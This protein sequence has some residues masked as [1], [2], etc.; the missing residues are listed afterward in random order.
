MLN[1]EA[2][3]TG[4]TV[5]GLGTLFIKAWLIVLLGQSLY[6]QCEFSPASIRH[7]IWMAALLGL[8]T[9]PLLTLLLPTWTL[10]FLSFE[11]SAEEMFKITEK[12]VTSASASVLIVN[13]LIVVYLSIA[14]LQGLRLAKSVLDI[15][16]ITMRAKPVDEQWMLLISQL[17]TNRRGQIKVSAEVK[18]PLTWGLLSPVIIVPERSVHWSEQERRMVLLHEFS[19]INRGDWFMQFLGQLVCILYWPVPGVRRAFDKLSLEAE[20]ACDDKVLGEGANAADYA[21]LLLRQARIKKL[22]ASVGLIQPS[23]FGCRVRHIVSATVDRT[24][25][26][27]MK[28]LLLTF[29]AVF[30]LPYASFQATASLRP[31]AV[32]VQP[33][34]LLGAPVESSS[35]STREIWAFDPI[36][37]PNR[38]ASVPSPPPLT[39][40]GFESTDIPKTTILAKFEPES[41]N[42]IPL[43]V[44]YIEITPAKKVMSSHPS[45]PGIA[46]RRGIEGRVVVQYDVDDT[47]TVLNPK[48]VYSQPEHVFN[49]SVLKAI[50]GYQFEPYRENGKALPVTGLREEFHFQLVAQP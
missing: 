44:E 10:S 6:E 48:V 20:Q 33:L 17:N 3:I 14:F 40:N 25:E 5:Y 38:P 2:L 12:G 19:H 41:L 37:R 16:L 18:S 28:R 29:C 24:G 22:Q 7:S 11:V 36:D 34:A 32:L 30:M 21:H 43:E 13:S 1:H 47:G 31:N 45:Y 26:K 15:S 42:P 35:A 27:S 39:I 23:E 8:F 49:R 9:L 4:I 46:A 50:S